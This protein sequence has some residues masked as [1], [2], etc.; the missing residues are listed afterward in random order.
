MEAYEWVEGEIGSAAKLNTIR[1]DLL[2][3]DAVAGF[4]DVQFITI[5]INSGSTSGTGTTPNPM[6]ARALPV[7]LG[8]IG[9]ASPNANIGVTLEKTD[10]TTITATRNGTSD[11]ITVKV[12][13]L[14]SRG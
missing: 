11:N 3:L 4:K 1:A 12:A 14:E 13:I 7:S 10:A 6:S 2:E 9:G 8:A 5:T